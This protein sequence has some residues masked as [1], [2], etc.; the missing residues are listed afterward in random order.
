VVEEFQYCW[1]PVP[2]PYLKRVEDR[3]DGVPGHWGD[4]KLESGAEAFIRASPDAFCNTS[5]AALLRQVLNDYDQ[6]SG[7]FFRWEVRYRQQELASLIREKSGIDFG[8][9]LD[10]VPV[11]R[12]ESGRLVRLKIVGS[13]RTLVVGKELE[14]RRWLSPSHLYSSAFVVEN[15]DVED[16]IPGSFLL[17]G[18][19][20]GHGVGL[21]QIGAAVMASKGYSHT[22]ILHHYFNDATIEKRYE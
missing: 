15:L 8:Q 19:G 9:I 20:W 1:E 18:A 16:G 4:L 21:C 17:R 10:L 3:P 14:I 6:R 13:L 12:G 5:D 11:Q 7:D 2:H 22:E